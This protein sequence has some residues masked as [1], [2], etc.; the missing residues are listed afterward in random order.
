MPLPL[1]LPLGISK[2]ETKKSQF[3]KIVPSDH[4]QFE[5]RGEKYQ[6]K[7]S[8][9]SPQGP[10]KKRSALEDLT[11][12][13]QSQPA[14]SKKEARKEFVKDISKKINRTKP[15]LELAKSN[16]MNIKQYELEPS[17]AAVSDTP[18]VLYIIKKPHTPR[19]FIISETPTTEEPSHIK[20]ILVLKEKPT[21]GDTVLNR[22]SL[23]LKKHINQN[24][25]PQFE[26]PLTLL[27][28]TESDLQYILEP[29]TFGKKQK[30]E[31]AVVTQRNLSFKEM[32]TCQGKQPCCEKEMTLPNINVEEDSFFME[33]MNLR[34]KPE[35]KEATPT[36]R[37]LTLNKCATQEKMSHEKKPLILQ[38]ATSGKESLIEKS[39]SFENMCTTEQFCFQESSLLQE[40]HTSQGEVSLLKKPSTLQKM[41]TKEE[42]LLKETL[43]FKKKRTIE[44]ATATK[45]LVI[46]KKKCTTRDKISCLK[47][48]YEAKS[49]IKEP[50][51]FKKKP[52]TEE[53]FLFKEASVLPEKHTTQ[54]EVS[55][56]KKPLVLQK[57]PT[58]E[59]SLLKETL[60]FKRKRTIEEATATKDLV[61]LKK[62][63]TTQDKISCL[64]TI[65]E[66]KS[67][68]KEP[69]SFKK[70]PTTEEEFLFKE[71]SV[72]PEKHTTQG[73]VSILKKPLV[74]QKSPTEEES[75]LKETLV[76][77]RK[78]TI[79][80]ATATKD[81][82][83]L[84][85]KCTTQDKISCLKKP[86]V[87]QT[88][89]EGKS[90]VKEPLSFK[91][92]PTTE[93]EFLF[94]ESSVLPEKHTTQGEVS[95]LKKPLVLQ[96]SPTEEESLLKET[97][98][99]K[100][101]R[102]IEEATATKDLVL[103]KRKC[104]TQDKISCLKKPLV[105]QT[106]SEGKSVIKE[107][108][109]FKQKPTTEEEFLF[110]ESS[111]LPEK[112]TTQREVALLKK[113]WA[114]RENI[115][116]KDEF[117]ME[118]VSLKKKHTMNEAISSKELISLKKK[119]CTTQIMMSTCQVILDL[120]NITD[121]DEDP[122]FMGPASL[123]KK[124]STE[125]AALTK[126]PSS[127]KKKRLTQG[128]MFLLE[129]P[130]VLDKTTSEEGSL[131][132]KALPFKK[133][134]KTNEE[135]LQQDPCLLKEDHTTLQKP[136]ALPEKT[137]TKEKSYIKEPSEK[138]PITEEEF[139][140]QEPF[141]LHVK[142]TNKDKSLFCKCLNRQNKTDSKEDSMKKLLTLQ[143]KSTT[144]K[145]S[146]FKKPLVLKKN[147]SNEA[148]TSIQSQLSLKKKPTPQGDVFPLK[149]Q[150]S[151]QKNTSNE[152]FLIKQPLKL[153]EKP[154]TKK[155]SLFKELAFH[156][157]STPNEAFH[158][159]MFSLNEKPTTG[160]EL[161]FEEPL[162]L[163]NNPTHR[164][165]SFLKDVSIQFESSP[166]VFRTTSESRIGMSSSGIM[167]IVRKFN[168]TK[169]SS[170][171]E[172]G[173]NK[174]FSSCGKRLQKEITLLEDIGK[175]HSNLTFDSIYVKAIFRYLKEREEKF[176]L[177]KYMSCQSDINNN[178]RAILVNWLVAAQVAFKVSHETLYLAV[179]LVD[180]YLMKVMC[181]K[182]KLQ[183]LGSTA[184]M[185]AAKFEESFPPGLDD[186]L[187][188]CND[189]YQRD[190][191]LAMEISIL[192][193][194]EF[195]IN[196][197]VAYHF[198]RRYSV[199]FR[200]NM[201]TLLL[202][203]FICEMTL[204]EYDYIQ[205]RASKLAAGSFLLALYM[206]N[207]GHLAPT[208]EY[209]SGYKTSD[210][211]PLVKKLNVLLTLRSCNNRLKAVHFKY[212]HRLFL[213][214][215]K[216]P[217]LNTWNLEE[218]LN[219]C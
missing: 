187:Y 173:S 110:K 134:P 118:P 97:L 58:E 35:T 133:K 103:L 42:S 9:S 3:S 68:I 210:L 25:I 164:K 23:S 115:H 96:K 124:S 38:K 57:S 47:T 10:L 29:E 212:S 144:E 84:K 53:E 170:D 79:E 158:F 123:R 146:L 178:M 75:L 41:T 132:Q 152:E 67:V 65:Y 48:I 52:T 44:E 11:N 8:S 20:K 121:K 60:V 193:T 126:T 169:K 143:E 74:L 204:Q 88:I 2:Q 176:I 46:L 107:P 157:K 161:S 186:F 89:S 77:K 87:L 105:L 165:D 180:H 188:I 13:S 129:K 15:P 219:S 199:C 177:K 18:M 201:D 82:V 40:K 138:K 182:D 142:P 209:Y 24:N 95:I 171:C 166:H 216:I 45:E 34:K 154:S 135:L 86:L 211:H 168:T 192:K 51:S 39:L 70:K 218:I 196:I 26:K 153:Q 5:K 140:F 150:L 149:K 28:E 54:G 172:S 50:S 106:I 141:S 14:Q 147:L 61:L 208:L 55:I 99:F 6:A 109:S 148:T 81:L 92:K 194:L 214:V 93:E 43:V 59:E 33:P 191:M 91:Q 213:E 206:K 189:A 197:P 36:K 195:D 104:T 1:P 56:L 4:G 175:N 98:V 72:L 128:K 80:E 137:T 130:L 62:K 179:K 127:T 31:E 30:T 83:L 198:L 112:H 49:V 162:A 113:P 12:A 119:E 7:I 94:K 122:F 90:V 131:L 156:G 73:E 160:Q 190:E 102:T 85:K 155:E 16:E 183:L 202:S 37:L 125:E 71:A 27:E 163:Q 76:F 139:L 136:L 120:Q 17:S 63:C 64:K 184:F 185:I 200:V 108:L 111:V 66:A 19:T 207:L 114:L 167:S 116:S 159:K 174:P 181:K 203:R 205:E 145:D 101:K 21:T 78:R 215:T 32:C 69:S 22:R 151:L 117:L 100:R 217:P